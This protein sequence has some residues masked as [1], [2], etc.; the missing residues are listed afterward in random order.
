MKY[1]P[2]EA[3]A[4]R[5]LKVQIL[6]PVLANQIAA[7]EVVERPV[8]AAK[9]LIENAIDAEATEITVELKGG[10]AQLLRISDNG[11]GMSRED[12]LLAL[13]RHATSKLKRVEDLDE[14][15][16][17]GFRGE[18]LPSIASVS[19][20]QL[21]TRSALDEVATRVQLSGGT[22]L[23]V[24]SAA[25][26]VGTEI[27]VEELFFNVPARR[28]FLKRASTEAGYIHEL[29]TRLAIVYPGIA[30][31][32][33]KD[34][35]QSID[36]P[37]H[38]DLHARLYALF[39]ARVAEAL[40]PVERAGGLRVSGFCTRPGHDYSTRRH[41]YSFV[42][43]RYIKDKAF[44]SAIQ[45]AYGNQLGR[46]RWPMAVLQLS[47]PPSEVDVN[48]HPAKT[49]VRF[50]NEGEIHDALRLA[51]IDALKE[52]EEPA[53]APRPQRSLQLAE[54]RAKGGLDSSWLIA[55]LESEAE[56]VGDRGAR[57][58]AGLN[59]AAS[60]D[61]AE[62]AAWTQKITTS[63]GIEETA[64][65]H[66]VR[67]ISQDML[68]RLS[69]AG[70]KFDRPEIE[71]PPLSGE[72]PAAPI[73]S[74]SKT[75]P[76]LLSHRPGHGSGGGEP[77]RAPALHATTAEH[78][79]HMQVSNPPI[80]SPSARP[81]IGEGP[82]DQIQIAALSPLG[83][84]GSEW[85]VATDQEGLL[86]LHLPT[87]RAQLFLQ[88][89][90][91]IKEALSPPLQSPQP[92]PPPAQL[93]QLAALSFTLEPFTEGRALLSAYP[94]ELEVSEVFHAVKALC[95]LKTTDITRRALAEWISKQPVPVSRCAGLIRAA[96]AGITVDPALPSPVAAF[97]RQALLRARG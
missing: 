30:F 93:T 84:C 21:R 65:N 78:E 41:L 28:K 6:D 50:A 17:L 70:G 90:Q 54:D 39:G 37:R 88:R 11:H 80:P 77:P 18:A 58:T 33:I 10:G 43:Q 89:N 19:R 60:A 29:V 9:E 73:T 72:Q 16:T 49:E 61:Q 42:N 56:D 22:D 59:Q 24:Q 91:L 35:H 69:G 86:A 5:P 76:P 34:G 97:S 64:L 7:G 1:S 81:L 4:S 62:M 95:Q 45:Q 26:P 74:R 2:G 96:K 8:N 67:R 38:G 15:R 12:A 63:E 31:R 32:L 57:K 20:F 71:T 82:S 47:I 52:A 14:I 75:R 46:G 85:W 87:L 55:R 48:V 68:Q 44:S 83:L 94:N 13:E 3:G 53:H 66:Q 25:G 23:K 40:I 92:L 27:R 51:L 79:R 36:L